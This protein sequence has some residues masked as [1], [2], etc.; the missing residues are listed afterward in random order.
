M[1]IITSAKAQKAANFFNG[2]IDGVA[3][4]DVWERY[5]LPGNEHPLIPL[6]TRPDGFSVSIGLDDVIQMGIFGAVSAVGAMIKNKNLM[7]RGIGGIVGTLGTK[8]MEF[9]NHEPPA[10]S[11]RAKELEALA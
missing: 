7:T 10:Y 9:T 2:M 8:V 4:N 5:K 1:K 3:L 6:G 11:K